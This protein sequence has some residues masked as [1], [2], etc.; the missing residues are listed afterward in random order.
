MQKVNRFIII[1]F[2]VCLVFVAVGIIEAFFD[3]RDLLFEKSDIN[4]D[5][6]SIKSLTDEEIIKESKY[7]AFKASVDYFNGTET[8]AEG[9]AKDEDSDMVDFNCER[10][11]GIKRVSV[12]KVA[13]CKLTLNISSDLIN[14]QAK[15][16]VIRDDEILEYL[17]LGENYTFTYEVTGEHIYIVKILCEEANL[18]IKVTRNMI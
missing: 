13:N 1:G 6:F 4:L 11:T 2:I 17:E 5:N 7:R 16:V 14:G 18:H 15:I 9:A 3:N 12:A 8:G 10:I